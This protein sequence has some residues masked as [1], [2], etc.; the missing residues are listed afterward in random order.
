MDGQVILCCIA[1]AVSAA[2][3]LLLVWRGARSN[4]CGGSCGCAKSTATESAQAPLI[5]PEEL[6]VRQRHRSD[7][8]Q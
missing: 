7:A 4:K 1:I 8:G 5:A 3:I 6:I 2:Y